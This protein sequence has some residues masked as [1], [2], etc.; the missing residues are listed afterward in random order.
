ME[1]D[2]RAFFLI[3]LDA[4][5]RLTD[6]LD[7]TWADVQKAPVDCDPKAGGGFHVACRSARGALRR[8]P[9][10]D[11][12][13]IFAD[14]GKA[15]TERDRRNGIQPDAPALLRGSR[16][17]PTAA[18]GRHHVP[19]GDAAHRRDADADARR[20]HRDRAEGRPLENRRRRTR[21]LSRADR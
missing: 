21:H 13:Y 10:P 8:C 11:S 9:K 18:A 5:V 16:T 3:G 19:L 14:V 12:P 7:V 6:I 17:C 2:D 1:P 4:L 15:E 20:R